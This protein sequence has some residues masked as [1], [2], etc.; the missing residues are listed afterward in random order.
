MRPVLFL[1]LFLSSSS[2]ELSAWGFYAHRLINKQ[3]VYSLPPELIVFFK[4]HLGYISDKAVNPDRRRYAVKGEAEKHYIDLDSYGDSAVYK[5][6]RFWSEAKAIHGEDSLRKHGI[7]PWS[8]FQT[9]QNLIY[10]FERKDAQAILRLA[11]DL[12]HYLGDIN[13]PLHSTKNYNGQFSGQYGIH[14]FWESRLPELFASEYDFFV[15]KASYLDFPQVEIWKAIETA[16]YALDSVFGFEES[17]TKT[18]PED[19]KYSYED[20]GGITTRVYS[21]EFSN[22]YHQKLNGQ[23]ERQMRNTIK[24]VADFWY[25]AWIL[26]GQPN[27]GYLNPDRIQVPNEKDSIYVP[28]DS[29]QYIREHRTYFIFPKPL[30]WRNSGKPLYYLQVF[31]KYCERRPRFLPIG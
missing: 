6:P 2:N 22:A 14:G 27:L 3:A 17:L 26:A 13:V 7:S 1:F 12:G 23:V 16:H 10:A 11:A 8:T 24:L 30:F 19:K 20:R 29:L 15:G 25:S 31:R 28:N 18:F 9:F 21:R 5:L 4:P